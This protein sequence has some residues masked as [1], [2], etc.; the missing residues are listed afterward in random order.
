MRDRLKMALEY[1]EHA[2][3]WAYTKPDVT[4]PTIQA[5]EGEVFALMI[6]RKALEQ[7]RGPSFHPQRAVVR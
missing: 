3:V 6:G 5:T 4:F 7:Y 1:D 2:K